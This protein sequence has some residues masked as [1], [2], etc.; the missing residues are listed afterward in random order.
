MRKRYAA[1][2]AGGTKFVCAVGSGPDNLELVRFPTTTPEQTLKQVVGFLKPH[3]AALRAVG[4]GSFGPVDLHPN[5]K[6]Y[7]HITTTPKPG[8]QQVDIVGEI[9]RALALPVAFNTDVNAAALGEGKWGAAQGLSDYIYITIGTGIGGGVV[10][11]GKLVHGLLH[12]E[13]G[14]CFL[15]KR[16]DDDFAG[17][18]P[19]H[20]DRC[21]EGLAS[22]PAIAARWHT[23]AE[24]LPATHPAWEMQADYIAMALVGYICCYSPEKIILGGGVMA[25]SQVLDKVR[26][27][28]QMHLNGYIQ[29]TAILDAIDHYLVAPGL[30]ARAGICGALALAQQIEDEE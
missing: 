21:F 29:H 25:R 15:P 17:S 30:G 24:D 22:G 1:V 28:V 9:A 12:T 6:T 7:G 2:E 19:F 5:S 10:S 20:A 26:Q 11:G 13:L 3:R 14:H 27:K 8:W 4:I 18:C 23:P 16:A